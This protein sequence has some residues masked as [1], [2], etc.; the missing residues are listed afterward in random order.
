MSPQCGACAIADL[1]ELKQHSLSY[2][3]L[4]QQCAKLGLYPNCPGS[5]AKPYCNP[6]CSVDSLKAHPKAGLKNPVCRHTGAHPQSCPLQC[7]TRSCIPASKPCNLATLPLN[8]TA[9]LQ[10]HETP[11]DEASPYGNPEEGDLGSQSMLDTSRPSDFASE[12]ASQSSLQQES[13]AGSGNS[14]G[15][16]SQKSGQHFRLDT[17]LMVSVS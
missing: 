7:H 13:L 10:G 17:S 12:P 8:C 15:L 2:S 9:H 6:V 5:Y 1:V 3:F 4:G 11:T 16:H 14:G